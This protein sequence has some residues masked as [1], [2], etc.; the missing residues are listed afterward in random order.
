MLRHY[1]SGGRSLSTILLLL[2]GTVDVLILRLHIRHLWPLRS[3]HCITGTVG[4]ANALAD[5]GAELDG[6]LRLRFGVV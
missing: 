2:A 3:L 5:E 4:F 6:A 1:S